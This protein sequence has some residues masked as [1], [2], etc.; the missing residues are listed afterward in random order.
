MAKATESNW[1]RNENAVLMAMRRGEDEKVPELVQKLEDPNI[2]HTWRDAEFTILFHASLEN[3]LVGFKALVKK[4]ADP[5]KANKYGTTVLSLMVKRGQMDMMEFAVKGMSQE[6]LKKFVN[7]RSTSG[8]TPLMAASEVNKI[9]TVKW[10]V[11][12]GAIVNS[13]MDSSG[14][15]AMHAAA[16]NGH[17]DIV[18]FL[19]E[20]DGNSDLLAEHREFGFDLKVTDVAKNQP[21]IEAMVEKFKNQKMES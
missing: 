21:E 19:L 12:R 7:C 17:N 14:W 16:K 11:E 8:W 10:L 13:Q 3:S 1:G 5:K 2:S 9:D 6:D 20:N 15:T 18:K 4:G